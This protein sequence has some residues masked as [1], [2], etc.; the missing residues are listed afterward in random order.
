M[1]S[2]FGSGAPRRDKY[3]GVAE[4]REKGGF[5][6]PVTGAGRTGKAPVPVPAAMLKALKDGHDLIDCN[7]LY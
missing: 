1:N 5:L 3:R 4:G 2:G 7:R 6:P